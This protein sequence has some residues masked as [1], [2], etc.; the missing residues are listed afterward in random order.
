MLFFPFKFD[1]PLDRL[2]FVTILVCLVCLVIYGIQYANEQKFVTNTERFC[3]VER[4]N[5]DRMALDKA[6]GSHDVG[7]CLGLMYELGLSDEP[8]VLLDQYAD[9]AEK[10][11]GLNEEDSRTYVHRFLTEL[12]SGYR[13]AVPPLTTKVL[14]YEPRSW[15]PLTM[16]S[17]SFA[18]GSWDHVIGNLFFF[19]AFAAA[20]E[21]IVGPLAFLGVIVA[22]AFGT[23]IFYSLA[24]LKVAEPLPTVGLSGIVMGM[25]TMLAY[26]MPTAKIRCF[27]WFLIKIGTFTVSAWILAL[28][29]VGF[30]IYNLMNQEEMGTV[31]LVA[32]VSG[33][34]IGL[35]F[36]SIFF[37]G[38]RRKLVFEAA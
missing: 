1:R 33:A 5:M 17:S 23:N 28:F 38:Q 27:Y 36:A 32:H 10:F 11:A 19:F 35:A 15:N 16:L 9:E 22:M 26:F 14:W 6:L 34:M 2:P 8:T 20:V 37:R 31:N 29:F 30:D 12:Y 18:H 25:M 13:R 21:L 4:S 24:M 7:A 3:N